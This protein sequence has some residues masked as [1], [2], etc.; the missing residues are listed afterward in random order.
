MAEIKVRR[1]CEYSGCMQHADF[2]YAFLAGN[3]DPRHRAM[4]EKHK[5]HLI[6]TKWKD[7]TEKDFIKIKEQ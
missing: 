4:C 3:G 1:Y 5:D 6:E 7:C 2:I